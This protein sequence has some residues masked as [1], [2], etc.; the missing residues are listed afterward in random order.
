MIRAGQRVGQIGE[1]ADLSGGGGRGGHRRMQTGVEK[2][3]RQVRIHPNRR[4][5]VL[6]CVT[7]ALG[8]SNRT[9]PGRWRARFA[10]RI[11]ARS[12]RSLASRYC[13]KS[14]P[15]KREDFC[16][17]PAIDQAAAVKKK[18]HCKKRRASH[19]QHCRP[20]L[21]LAVDSENL[22]KDTADV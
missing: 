8:A 21:L 12:G 10:K 22:D 15:T 18:K 14:G 17:C 13:C 20:L 6:R 1:H 9:R 2:R 4:G 19:Q 3:R 7:G 5:V 11:R 16:H